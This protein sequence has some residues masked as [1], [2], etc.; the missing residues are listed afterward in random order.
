MKIKEVIDYLDQRL[1]PELQED[2]DNA[3]YLLGDDNNEYTGAL[4]ALDLTPAVVEEACAEGLS[5]IVTHH[6]FIF[7]GAKQLTTRSELGRMVHRLVKNNIAVYAAHTNL[8]NLA[9]GVNGALAQ[10]LGLTGCRILKPLPQEP[11]AGAG[12]VGELP[13]PLEADLLLQ[14]VKSL[15]GSP[16]L[17]TS[18]HATDRRVQRVALCGGSGA[19]FIGDAMAAGADIYITA[20]M[21]YHDFQRTEGRMILC[22]AGHY[23]SE[24][25]AREVIFSVISE[26]FCTFAC[27]ISASQESI[28]QY[29]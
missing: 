11:T 2:Y 13:Q 5:L 15:L 18:P 7:V 12:M 4:V 24:Q 27:R 14:R 16:T 9:W 1:R 3:G 23:E 25:F 19:E 17:R 28:I 21:K 10:R 29:I 8:D 20:D 6:P 22:D 26:K